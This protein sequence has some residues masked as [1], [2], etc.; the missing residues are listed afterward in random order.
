VA[1]M[2]NFSIQVVGL[3]VIPT[4]AIVASLIMSIISFLRSNEVIR[5]KHRPSFDIVGLRIDRTKLEIFAGVNAEILDKEKTTNLEELKKLPNNDYKKLMS[6]KN[7]ENNIDFSYKQEK[8]WVINFISRK[9]KK[10]IF[11][12]KT[13]LRDIEDSVLIGFNALIVDFEFDKKIIRDIELILGFTLTFTRDRIPSST[14]INANFKLSKEQC[15]SGKMTLPVS[16]I[17]S[18]GGVENNKK[19]QLLERKLT[20]SGEDKINLLDYE[21]PIPWLGFKETGYLM[22][23]TTTSND[24]FDYSVI[25]TVEEKRCYI[26]PISDNSKLFFERAKD[27][28]KETGKR[29]IQKS[30]KWRAWQ[31]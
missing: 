25:I 26:H 12:R 4:I 20:N 22:R 27:A 8:H 7:F 23:V 14:R 9:T 17:C 15:N 21:D 13:K 18:T 1:K 28:K 2:D 30:S 5:E 6:Y 11:K 3:L 31:K 16:Y 19:A 29:V 24:T 10:R